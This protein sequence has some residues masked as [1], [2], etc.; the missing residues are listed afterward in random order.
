MAT[1]P[2][3]VRLPRLDEIVPPASRKAILQHLALLQIG[4]IKRRTKAGKDVEGNSFAPYSLRYKE[5]R[6]RAGWGMKPDLWLRGGML[7]SLGVI[8]ADERRAVIGFQGSSPRTRFKARSRPVASKKGGAKVDLT[9]METTANVANA[10][11]AYWNQ[12]GRKPRRFFAL[13]NQDRVFLTKTALDLMLRAVGQ[14]TLQ[15]ALGR[16]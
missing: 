2:V 4:R 1:K 12:H 15:R 13:S 16:K 3:T 10:L 9:V 5:Q 7:G 8:E 6:R 14:Q 11:K